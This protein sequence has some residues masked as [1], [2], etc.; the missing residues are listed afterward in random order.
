MNINSKLKIKDKN[1]IFSG[2]KDIQHAYTVKLVL[3][4]WWKFTLTL[5]RKA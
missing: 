4:A 3:Y 1:V 2:H 5:T